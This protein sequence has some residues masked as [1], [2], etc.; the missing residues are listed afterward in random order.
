[1]RIRGWSSTRVVRPT[2]LVTIL[3]AFICY[4]HVP[5]Y[6]VLGVGPACAFPPGAYNT[7]FGISNLV[8]FSMGPSVVMLVLGLLTVKNVRQVIKR[9]GPNNTDGQTQNR[10]LHRQKA[11][12]RQLI[13]MMLLQ[14]VFFILTATPTSL[15]YCYTAAMANFALNAVETAR[16]NWTST[17]ISFISLTGPCMSFYVF[18]LASPLFRRE[19]IQLFKCRQQ[20]VP[21]GTVNTVTATQQK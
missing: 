2:V 6:T 12:D 3:L 16:V 4:V 5:I 1:M 14:C 11:T 9:V 10:Q 20:I 7:F 21:Y 13:R 8:F 17:V 15:Y 18:T 19:L